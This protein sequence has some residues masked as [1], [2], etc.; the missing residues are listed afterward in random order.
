LKSVLATMLEPWLNEHGSLS[1]EW[2]NAKICIPRNTAANK[3]VC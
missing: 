3:R 2:M 1:P